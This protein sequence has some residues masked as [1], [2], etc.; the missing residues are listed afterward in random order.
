MD[1]VIVVAVEAVASV[2]TVPDTAAPEVTVVIVSAAPKPL[3]PL[4]VKAPTSPFEVFEIVMVAS[5]V[6]VKE[7]A[8]LLPAANALPLLAT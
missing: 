1:S 2:R 7:Q 3:L 5:F 6:F 4:N 8:T